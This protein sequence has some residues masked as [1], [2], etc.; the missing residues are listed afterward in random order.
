MAT[1]ATQAKKDLIA[2]AIGQVRRFR[3]CGRLTTLM[4]RRPSPSDFAT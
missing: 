2:T 4:S 3:F 1:V